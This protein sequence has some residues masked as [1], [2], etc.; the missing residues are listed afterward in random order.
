M[1]QEREP[2]ADEQG[3]WSEDEP[4]E[5]GALDESGDFDTAAAAVPQEDYS[6]LSLE[7]F[8]S[9]LEALASYSE[10]ESAPDMEGVPEPGEIRAP[11]LADVHDGLPPGA[12]LSS[13][14]PAVGDEEQLRQPRAQ[15][16][17]RGLRHQIGMLPLALYCLAL[18]GFLL[19]RGQDV[20]GLPDLSDALLRVSAVVAIGFTL[21]FH[22]LVFGRRERGLLFLGLW[23]L[24]TVGLAAVLIYGLDEALDLDTWW[25]L[26]IG[27]ASVALLLTY[28]LER[29]HDARLVLLSVMALV[30]GAV[31][32][33]V[34]SERISAERVDQVA[35]YWPLLLAVVGVGLL[36]LV[37]RRRA[38]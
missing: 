22:A 9:E 4:G 23:I 16:F 25:P 19:A 36:P 33:G 35:E 3:Q 13:E 34:S 7:A 14:P 12:G 6:L 26:G 2:W 17:R 15:R 38:G 11:E 8:E 5:G 10:D 1:S 28:L 24:A 29:A 31:A 37:I 21:V 30:A 27:S 18:G 32:Y 20:S